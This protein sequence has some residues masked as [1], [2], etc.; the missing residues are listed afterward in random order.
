VS[1]LL[2]VETQG[3]KDPGKSASWACCIAHLYAKYRIPPVLLITCQDK[4]TAT[5]AAEPI[6]IGPGPSP[7]LALT[8]ASAAVGLPDGTLE[9]VQNVTVEGIQSANR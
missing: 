5:S 3:K 4:A 9:A 6:T 8:A 2:V 1:H 7:S